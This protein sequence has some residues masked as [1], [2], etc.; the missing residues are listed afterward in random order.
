MWWR[1]AA[2]GVRPGN[3]VVSPRIPIED[4]PI[5]AGYLQGVQPDNAQAFPASSDAVLAKFP[6]TLLLTGTRAP[7]MSGQAFANARL[8]ALGV[9][10]TLYLIEGARHG[11]IVFEFAAP[12]SL[13]AQRFIIKWFDSHLAR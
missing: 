4:N 1:I 8:L 7:E 11:A 6:P 3:L 10:S 13:D 5:L 9:D 12:E 2:G